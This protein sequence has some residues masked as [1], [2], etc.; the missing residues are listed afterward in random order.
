MRIAARRP[1]V[2]FS[3]SPND[4]LLDLTRR[5]PDSTF[6]QKGE[7]L[8]ELVATIDKMSKLYASQAP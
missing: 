8:K 1:V 4:E 5:I 3:A 6:V 7:S 2:F